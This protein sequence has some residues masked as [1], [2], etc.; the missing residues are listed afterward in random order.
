MP[1]RPK[2][3]VLLVF[4][5]VLLGCAGCDHASKQVA[6]SA[7]A[8]PGIV[9]IAGGVLRLELTS[10]PGAFL[11]L[12]AGLPEGVRGL[13]FMGLIPLLLLGFCTQLLRSREASVRLAVAVGLVAGGGLA[14]WLDRLLHDGAV[15][16]FLTVVLGPLHTGVFNVA[17][18]AVVCGVLALGFTRRSAAPPCEENT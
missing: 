13:L 18:V 7:L 3:R 15:T 14:N 6:L 9:S 10:N 11:S 2:A 8:E 1:M 16:D 5:T 12:G 4:L 17:D